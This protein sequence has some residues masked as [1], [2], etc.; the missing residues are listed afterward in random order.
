MSEKQV[1]IAYATRYGSTRVTAND[2]MKKL[3]DK[4]VSVDIVDLKTTKKRKWPSAEAYNVVLIGSSIMMGK[5]MG[6]AKK[7]IS[8]NQ[9]ELKKTGLGLF[10]SC[11]LT[12]EDPAKAREEYIQDF[13]SE[14]NIRPD[15]SGI[16]APC[17]D[18][19]EDSDLGM[20]KKGI[21]RATIQEMVK[22]RDDMEITE[23]EICDLRNAAKIGSFVD[24]IVSIL[25]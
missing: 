6:E 13:S 20:I 7:F 2:I 23:T 1:L 21:L 15:V 24:E 12:L 3:I 14:K 17:V 11:G 8:R 5:W 10:V 9:N 18:L 19:T 22:D 25:E 16:F 4:G